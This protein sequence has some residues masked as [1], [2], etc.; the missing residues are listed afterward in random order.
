MSWVILHW[1]GSELTRNSQ[2]LSFKCSPNRPN[3]LLYKYT[4]F[5]ANT[6]T[7]TTTTPTLNQ[8]QSGRLVRLYPLSNDSQYTISLFN[9]LPH[10]LPL[11]TLLLVRHIEKLLVHL[12]TRLE[13]LEPVISECKNPPSS[14]YSP[15]RR[16]LIHP[17][18]VGIVLPTCPLLLP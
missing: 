7:T 8:K 13:E 6:T 12:P 18:G 3:H 4:K 15:S 1:I 9:P 17:P 14:V 16:N 11:P 2:C 5:L 10:S